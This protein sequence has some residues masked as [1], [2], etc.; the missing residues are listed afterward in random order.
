[1]KKEKIRVDIV[2][3]IKHLI[4]LLKTVLRYKILDAISNY[5]LKQSHFYFYIGMKYYR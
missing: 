4:V 5:Q 1:M 2:L 3:R